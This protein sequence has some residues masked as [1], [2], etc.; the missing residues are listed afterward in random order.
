MRY[1]LSLLVE[2][3]VLWLLLSGHFNAL[4]LGFGAV[5]CLLVAWLAHRMAVVDDETQ[6][7]HLFL[8]LPGYWL[9]LG[10]EIVKAN[11][12]VIKCVLSP[13][14]PISPTMGHVQ[15]QELSELGHVIYANSITLTP[16]TISVALPEGA[17][18]VHA[19]TGDG[20]ADLKEGAM[21][22]RV[23]AVEGRTPAA[24]ND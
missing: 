19:L 14:M 7:Q 22:R 3:A 15:A 13:R 23:L 1:S 4:F 8:R 11:V 16:G 21:H 24:G 17:I 20:F 2:L 18:E 5:S 10:W 12:D 9:W 6:P